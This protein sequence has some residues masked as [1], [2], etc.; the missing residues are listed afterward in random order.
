MKKVFIS[1]GHGGSDS[2][3]V[4]NGFKEKDLNLKI[5]L[6]V[7][8]VLL[9][10]GVSVLMSR[11]KD[12]N[13]PI[14][15]EAKECN[16]F[17]PDL[18][19]S[20]H[21]NAGGGDGAECW[22]SINGGI[23]K[24]LALNMLDEVTKIGQNSRGAKTKKGNNGRD[25]YGFIR[26][27]NA[28]AVIIEC[29]FIDNA[30]D[31]QIINTDEKCKTMGKAIAYGIAK[32]LGVSTQPTVQPTKPQAPK[33]KFSQAVQDFQKSAIA[34][35]FKFPK[36]GA[37]GYWGEECI[38]VSK[39]AICK[40]VLPKYINKNLTKIVQKAVGVRI[41]GYYGNDTYKAVVNWQKKNGLVPDGCFGPACWKKLLGV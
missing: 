38:A 37:D 24:T 13:D 31:I 2:G 29:A 1:A 14:N 36:S 16:A 4:G 28:P 27:T 7:S 15:D 10:F 19:V 23:G 11:T 9:S 34:D 5:A 21:N 32:T 35:G 30:K 26:Q 17:K 3:A 39:K 41:D 25:Y 6:A 12:E 20:I 22:Y 18:A 8:Q 40:R 33:Q